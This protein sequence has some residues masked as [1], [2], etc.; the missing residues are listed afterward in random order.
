MSHLAQGTGLN[1]SSNGVARYLGVSYHQIGVFVALCDATLI[2]CASILGDLG[3]KYW[4]YG[5][6]P[7]AKISFGVG[8][9]ACVIYGFVGRS[10]GLYS[11][12]TLLAAQQRL[13]AL[14]LAWA[15]M[16]L[17][18]LFVL[19]LLKVGIVFSRGVHDG[20]G[21]GRSLVYQQL[22][23]VAR[24]THRVGYLSRSGARPCCPLSGEPRQCS[25]QDGITLSKAIVQALVLHDKVAA[26]LQA[27]GATE[28]M[29]AVAVRAL[30]PAL[31]GTG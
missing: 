29:A 9:V 13:S 4:W 21:R 7:D 11:L 18:L 3:Y 26:A 14:V 19:F 30:Q 28:E 1:R 16:F 23:L 5:A 2:V 10:W 22:E 8:I 25:D 15:M 6:F 24:F 27:A 20:A 12:P 17:V 31:Q